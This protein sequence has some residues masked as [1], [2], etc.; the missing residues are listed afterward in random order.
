MGRREG[1][2]APDGR[3]GRPSGQQLRFRATFG[4]ALG[5]DA[6]LRFDRGAL[7]CACETILLPEFAPML[8]EATQGH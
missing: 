6:G 7:V 8:F 2:P 5:C 1:A 4:L 3:P